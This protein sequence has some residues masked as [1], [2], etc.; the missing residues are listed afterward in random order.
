VHAGE[1]LSVWAFDYTAYLERLPGHWKGTAIFHPE[2]RPA[3][4]LVTAPRASNPNLH[5]QD[6]VFTLFK[7]DKI[8][9]LEGPDRRPLNEQVAASLFSAANGN[10]LFLEFTLPVAESGKMMSR[11]SQIGVNA[12][13]L[14]PGYGGAVR[15][16]EEELG[17]AYTLLGDEERGAPLPRTRCGP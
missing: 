8:V 3:V 12:A 15:T 4:H 11:L 5:S 16:L 17:L 6:G 7:P 1:L 14:F 9:D 13:T 2:I 10:P